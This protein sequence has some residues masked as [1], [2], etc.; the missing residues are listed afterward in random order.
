MIEVHKQMKKANVK[1]KLLLQVHDELVFDVH[2]DELELM[3]NL[4]REAMT[5]A[6]RLVVPMEVESKTAQN[7]LD[8]H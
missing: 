7:W 4:V 2:K 6:V 3:K 1:S 8:A 5:N